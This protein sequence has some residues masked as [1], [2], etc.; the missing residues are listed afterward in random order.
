MAPADLEL[1]FLPLNHLSAGI[2]Y[3]PPYL[4][5]TFLKIHLFMDIYVVR[6]SRFLIIILQGTWE[7][8]YLSEIRFLN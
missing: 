3:A 5:S 1:A 8:S 7:C 2:K 4:D 6:L